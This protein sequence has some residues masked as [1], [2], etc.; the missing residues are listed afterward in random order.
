[1]FIA[2][3]QSYVYLSIFQIIFYEGGDSSRVAFEIKCN[4]EASGDVGCEVRE[5]SL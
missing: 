5:H 3:V 4:R 1:M 2:I